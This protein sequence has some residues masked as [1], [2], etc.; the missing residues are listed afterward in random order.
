MPTIICFFIIEFHKYGE[1]YPPFHILTLMPDGNITDTG[2]GKE[3]FSWFERKLKFKYVIQ[4]AFVRLTWID[5]GQY[6]NESFKNLRVSYYYIPNDRT[7]AKYSTKNDVA[8]ITNLFTNNVS[9]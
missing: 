8:I 9:N 2:A 4:S 5:A 1:K 6:S 7:K 3:Y